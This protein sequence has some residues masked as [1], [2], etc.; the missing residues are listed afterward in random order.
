M[1][2]AAADSFRFAAERHEQDVVALRSLVP[3]LQRLAEQAEARG[4]TYERLAHQLRSMGREAEQRIDVARRV[5]DDLGAS[6]HSLAASDISGVSAMLSL[7]ASQE[8]GRATDLTRRRRRIEDD[9]AKLAQ[10][11]GV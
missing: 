6:R 3:V 4:A 10:S 5:G 11:L 8:H 9:I 7:A 2:I 1:T